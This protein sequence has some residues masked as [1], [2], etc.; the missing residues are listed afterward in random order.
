MNRSAKRIALGLLGPALFGAACTAPDTGYNGA[1][2]RSIAREAQNPISKLTKVGLEN[3][4]NFGV[5]IDDEVQYVS[6]LQVNL[7]MALDDDWNV[8]NVFRLPLLHQPEIQPGEGDETGLGNL[9]YTGFFALDNEVSGMFGFGP[10][11]VADTNSGEQ[12]GPNSTA[13]GL[14]VL[15]IRNPGNW[16]YGGQI[17]NVWNIPGDADDEISEIQ[18]SGYVSY[19]LDDGWYWTSTPTIIGDWDASSSDRWT[20]PL[21]GGFGRVV[22][23]GGQPVNFSLQSFWN[24]ESPDRTGA[25]WAIVFDFELLYTKRGFRSWLK[26]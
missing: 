2:V 9:D 24:L 6:N 21:G 3:N 8:I 17:R 7:P 12:L 26:E 11:I 25:D 23:F 19:N 13:A 16:V 15:A 10:V 20:V 1:D 18:L 5:G 4:F 14:A 22:K